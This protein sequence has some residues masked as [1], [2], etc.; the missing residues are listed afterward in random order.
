ME[1][2]NYIND[3]V[4][5][6]AGYNQSARISDMLANLLGAYIL[7][8]NNGD[9]SSALKSINRIHDIVSPKIKQEESEI[10][11]GMV[12][13]IEVD[14][15]TAMETFNNAGRIY[16]KNPQQHKKMYKDV[17]KLFR[18]V[19]KIQDKYGYGMVSQDDPRLAVT[20]R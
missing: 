11:D 2:Q 10:V 6:K 19:N 9:Y 5:E 7:H 1:N 8:M 12:D 13:K 16:I 14:L 15:Q 3:T 4:G 20:Q 17:A 18:F